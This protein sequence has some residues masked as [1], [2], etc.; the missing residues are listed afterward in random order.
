MT[1]KK[2]EQEFSYELKVPKD[3]IAVLIGKDG[4][5]KKELEDETDS[6]IRIDSKEGDVEI[7]GKDSIGLF[8]AKEVIRA[9]SRGFNPE[10]AR[11][12]LK[13]DYMFEMLDLNDYAKS[14][15]DQIRLK[16]RVIGSE[17]KSRN[18]IED[19]TDTHISVYGKT[20]GI[21]GLSDNV[22]IAKQAIESILEGSKHATVF[23]RL[24]RKKKD[25]KMME[26]GTKE[27]FIND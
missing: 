23:R 13:Q 3:R 27:N 10:I 1:S 18:V 24:E 19:L 25:L 14:K 7:I 17:G 26:F 22:F 5:I 2:E 20:I 6:K 4:I 15:N 21:I 8:S 11:L 9:I 16:G 12:L